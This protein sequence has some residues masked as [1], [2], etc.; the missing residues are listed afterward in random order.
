MKNSTYLRLFSLV[1]GVFLFGSINAQ[2][3][4]TVPGNYATVQQ[5]L[6]AEFTAATDG[7]S[8]IIQV[9]E[10]VFNAP[11]DNNVST[12][13]AD[14][15]L[16]IT[17]QGA[18]ADKTFQR[19]SI[20]SGVTGRPTPA[21]TG[22][23][24]WFQISGTKAEANKGSSLTIKNMTFQY[25]GTYN[26]NLAAG[27]ALNLIMDTEMQVTIENV[28]YDSN[29]GQAVVNN[30]RGTGLTFQ[31]C[32]FINNVST[33]RGT[34]VLRGVLAKDGGVF[35]IRNTTF[36]SNEFQDFATTYNGYI[37]YAQ[38]TATLPELTLV[39]ENNAFVN[40]RYVKNV[41]SQDE[42]DAIKPI[43]TLK[44]AVGTV[45]T[46][47]LTN[48]IMVGNGRPGQTKDVDLYIPNDTINLTASG[49]ILTSAVTAST[50]SGFIAYTFAGSKID[51]TYTYTDSRINFTMDGNLPQLILDANFIGGVTY[52]GDGGIVG[53]DNVKNTHLKAYAF[54]NTLI[55][56]GI[57]AG[58][59]IEIYTITG[60][61]FNRSIV[62][63]DEFEMT[64][65]K[66][67]YIIRY[68][69]KSQ[70]VLVQ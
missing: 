41:E 51:P 59:M 2:R 32:L 17:I 47:T 42:L 7:E 27:S 13:P 10:G 25:F 63:S 28:V 39:M 56:K 31:N 64:I 26:T 58:K 65:P 69:N 21:T 8:I 48:N 1:L 55:V 23:T 67:L 61:V 16:F 66:G 53:F 9:G 34:N 15:K 52:T 14:K 4:V 60:S 68:E 30:P 6:I 62:K 70:K 46:A 22:V 5:A 29:V 11:V 45:Y 20:A 49:N 57:Q 38:T 44:R 36:Y 12:W 24:R 19:P 40:N 43:I 50:E 35:T 3:T 54:N 18:G 33:T 37:V